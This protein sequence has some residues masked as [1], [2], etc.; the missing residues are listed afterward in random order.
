MAL[1]FVALEVGNIL[2]IPSQLARSSTTA[3]LIAFMM[4]FTGKTC[5]D[6]V[7]VLLTAAGLPPLSPLSDHLITMVISLPSALLTNMY[8]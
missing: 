2:I 1:Q 8:P 6:A 3:L 5:L 4:E 7:A